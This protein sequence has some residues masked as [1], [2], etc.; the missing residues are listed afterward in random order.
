[1]REG[2]GPRDL[3]FQLSENVPVWREGSFHVPI[4]R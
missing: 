1:V 4:L 2:G 3:E